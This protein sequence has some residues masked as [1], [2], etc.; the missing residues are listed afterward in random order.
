TSG[1]GGIF[2]RGLPVGYVV[3]GLDGRWRVVLASDRAPIDYVRILLFEDF[4]QVA[5]RAGLD[6]VEVPPP[7]PGVPPSN[8]LPDADSAQAAAA[9]ALGP[10]VAGTTPAAP[11]K[12]DA[13]AKTAAPAAAKIGRAH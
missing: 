6:K 2:P 3:K 5:N 4:T 11:A 1:E 7:T 12:P 8:A 9:A 10:T 13:A